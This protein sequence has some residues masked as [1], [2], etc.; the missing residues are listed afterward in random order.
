[1]KAGSGQVLRRVVLA[2]HNKEK[3]GEL[4]ALLGKDTIEVATLDEFPNVG[5]IVEDGATLEEN[6]LKKAGTVFRATGLPALADDSGLEVYYL[7]MDPGVFSSRYSGPAATYGSNC[8]KLLEALRGV[9]PRRRAAR[10]RCVL[11]LVTKGIEEI[12]EGTCEGTILEEP[13]GTNGFGYDPVFQ[14]K[15]YEKTFA[16]IEPDLKNSLSHRSQAL[17]KMQPI[18]TSLSERSG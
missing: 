10:F 16:E 13:R 6:A 15:G 2:T 12:V 8:R 9:P 4:R 7:N 1:M 17:I 11:A 18:L 3:V 14:P 5:E